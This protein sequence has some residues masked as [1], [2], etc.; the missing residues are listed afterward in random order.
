MVAAVEADA[1]GG[2]GPEQ[3][4]RAEEAERAGEASVPK[5]A[6]ASAPAQIAA[7]T[8][9]TKSM[10]P[11]TMPRRRGPDCS[12]GCVPPASDQTPQMCCAWRSD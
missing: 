7:A 10:R 11:S 12:N 8:S 1:E 4:D 9:P 6:S 5:I 2:E 3:P